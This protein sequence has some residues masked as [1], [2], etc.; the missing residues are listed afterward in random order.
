MSIHRQGLSAQSQANFWRSLQTLNV[1]RIVIVLVLLVYL[2]L[3][4]KN[5]PDVG[6]FIPDK[7]FTCYLMLATMFALLAIYMPRRFL[8]QLMTQIGFDI[9][10]ISLLYLSAGG[11]R[12]GLAILYLFPLAGAAI[13]APLSMALLCTALVTLFLLAE[14]A[15][16]IAMQ[17]NEL[18]VMQAGMYGAAMFAV[19]LL[20]NRLASRLIGQEELAVQRGFSLDIL[21]AINLLVIADI[22][23]GIVVVGR[24][25]QVLTVNPAAAQMLGL[26]I[27]PGIRPPDSMALHPE[28]VYSDWLAGIGRGIKLSDAPALQSVA[29]AYANWLASCAISASPG[30]NDASVVFVTVKPYLTSE[31]RRGAMGGPPGVSMLC[32]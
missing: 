24:D 32:S 5:W 27:E 29:R 1:T 15:Y 17:G 16:Q 23:D 3:D 9:A 14:S 20:V 2:S 30:S 8:L 18:A 31:R 4:G 28:R 10:V 22:D 11:G 21:Q 19:V 6:S 12:S 25:G 13:L 7:V 26:A